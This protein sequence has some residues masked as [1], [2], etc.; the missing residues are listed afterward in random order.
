MKEDKA[1]GFRCAKDRELVRRC[2]RKEEEAWKEFTA[3]Y[4]RVIHQQIHSFL[5]VRAVSFQRE[6]VEDFSHSVFLAFLKDDS[7]K[8]RCFEGKC[9][10]TKWVRIITTNEII[11][12]LRREKPR[13][14]LEV[15][16][17]EGVCLKD[18]LPDPRPGAEESLVRAQERSILHRA[19]GKVSHEDRKLALLTYEMEMPV[20]KIAALLRISKEAVYTRKHR[21]QE[22]LRKA[23]GQANASE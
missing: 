19:F 15:T 17:P 8:L 22:K 10:L 18:T 14:S 16:S 2:I 11:D 1:Q 23:L 20:D 12:Q 13:V 5:Q 7:R 6:D 4:S 21:L 3:R 9:S